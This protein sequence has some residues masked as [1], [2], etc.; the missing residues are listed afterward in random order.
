MEQHSEFEKCYMSVMPVMPDM[1]DISDMPGS[2]FFGAAV[3]AAIY[4]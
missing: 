2:G 1:P 4:S 3:V